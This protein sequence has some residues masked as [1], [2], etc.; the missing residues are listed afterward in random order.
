MNSGQASPL[1][2]SIVYLLTQNPMC[3]LTQIPR[4]PQH[5]RQQQTTNMPNLQSCTF[6][7]IIH[8]CELDPSRKGGGFFSKKFFPGIFGHSK[9]P[10]GGGGGH[11]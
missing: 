1:G 6:G 9:P 2:F 8:K 3:R 11:P 7:F 5:P 10:G 4:S